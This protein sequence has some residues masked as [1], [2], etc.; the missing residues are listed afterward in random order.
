VPSIAVATAQSGEPRDV[1][2]AGLADVEGG[3]AAVA[4]APYRIGSITKTFTAALVLSLA[5]EGHLALD[6]Q[7]ER[8]LPDTPLGEV[9]LRSLLAHCGGVQREAPVDMWRSMQGPDRQEL[10]EALGRARLVDRPGARWHYSNLGY[11]VVGEIVKEV[12]ARLRGPDRRA[13]DRPARG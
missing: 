6:A 11:A 4:T 3:V 7:V 1:A 12:T 5:E 10:L 13:V 8:Y 9:P 2:V